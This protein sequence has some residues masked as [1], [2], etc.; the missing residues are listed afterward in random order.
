MATTETIDNLKAQVI[1]KIEWCIAKYKQEFVDEPKFPV[2]TYDLK[3]TTAGMAYSR[4]NKIRLNLELL[5]KYKDDFIN[6]TVVHEMAHIFVDYYYNRKRGIY[7]TYPKPHG[8]EW[9]D[10]MYQLEIKTVTRCHSY[11]VAPSRTQRRF[12]YTCNCDN[13]IHSISLTKHNRIKRGLN[14]KCV[15]CGTRLKSTGQEIK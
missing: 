3:G 12:A 1:K 9:R 5:I 6:R 2:V 11:Q 10:M 8:K 14:Y 7:A 15:H 4:A 13:K